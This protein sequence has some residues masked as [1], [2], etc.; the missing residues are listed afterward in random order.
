MYI[1]KFT[2]YR[3]VTF[4]VVKLNKIRNSV[5]FKQVFF[6]NANKKS[7]NLKSSSITTAFLWR[8]NL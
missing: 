8:A 6:L 1:V 2:M 4:N 7:A 5:Q 3:A